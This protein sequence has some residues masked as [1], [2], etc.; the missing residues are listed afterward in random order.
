MA[1]LRRFHSHHLVLLRARS[2]WEPLIAGAES[3]WIVSGHSRW[4]HNHHRSRSDAESTCQQFGCM[5]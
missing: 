2:V 1:R 3:D 5:G 4:N